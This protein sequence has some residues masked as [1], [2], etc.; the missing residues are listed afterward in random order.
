MNGPK[1]LLENMDR[2]NTRM[3]ACFPGSRAVFRGHD[4]HAELKDMDWIELYVFGIT[5]RHFTSHQVR[6]L[7]AMWV[8]TSYPDVRIWNNRIA[9]LAGS[10][11]STPSLALAASLAAS[12][13]II[14]GGHAFVRGIDFLLQTGKKVKAG[15]KLE[16]VVH[17]ELKARRIY[18]FGRPINSADERIPWLLKL[19]REL[20][21]GDGYHLRLAFEVERVL[22]AKRM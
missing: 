6:L 11:R 7:H 21:L 9:G 15:E 19:A 10:S 12:E 18:G 4:L 1:K 5:G 2:L 16:D 8:C 3:G 22:V 14:Y 13:A 20:D 17:C